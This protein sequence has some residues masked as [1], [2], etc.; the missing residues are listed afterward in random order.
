M[1]HVLQEGLS[2]TQSDCDRNVKGCVHLG[3]QMARFTSRFLVLASWPGSVRQT[4]TCHMNLLL[5]QSGDLLLIQSWIVPRCGRLLWHQPIRCQSILHQPITMQRKMSMVREKT[6]WYGNHPP[7]YYVEESNVNSMGKVTS[8]RI[9][10]TFII[11]IIY[12][13]DNIVEIHWVTDIQH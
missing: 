9:I 6:G 10:S 11:S 13:H 3:F 5:T 1:Y 8:G 2:E 7:P 12:V 4:Q